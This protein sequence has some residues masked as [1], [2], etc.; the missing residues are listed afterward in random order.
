MFLQVPG[1]SANHEIEASRMASDKTANGPVAALISNI[2]QS[3]MIVTDV[4]WEEKIR[5]YA[6]VTNFQTFEQ[7]L[8]GFLSK[9]WNDFK[10]L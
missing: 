5:G 3:S 4:Q 9:I 1:E 8:A 7:A 10:N 2:G 6:A